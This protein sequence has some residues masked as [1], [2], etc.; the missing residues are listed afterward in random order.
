MLEHYR[1][2]LSTRGPTSKP[3]NSMHFRPRLSDHP[4]QTSV[5]WMKHQL[6]LTDKTRLSNQR[7]DSFSRKNEFLSQWTQQTQEIESPRLSHSLSSVFS[8]CTETSI[9]MRRARTGPVPYAL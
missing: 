3:E 7:S 4:G 8:G 6:C 1:P 2:M 5:R 9:D